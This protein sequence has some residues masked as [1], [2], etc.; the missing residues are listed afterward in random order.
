M[1]VASSWAMPLRTLPRL[2]VHR[3]SLELRECFF[4]I[5]LLSSKVQVD[6][7]VITRMWTLFRLNLC[8]SVGTTIIQVPANIIGVNLLRFYLCSN[9]FL[10]FR[11]Q[12]LSNFYWQAWKWL[13]EDHEYDNQTAAIASISMSTSQGS[14]PAWIHVRAGL[15]SGISWKYWWVDTN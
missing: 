15:G 4:W 12:A 2:L 6:M 7:N 13:L 11:N 3:E 14:P 10:S 9:R 5:C 8:Y 1:L